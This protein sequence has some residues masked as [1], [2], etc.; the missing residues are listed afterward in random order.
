MRNL[1]TTRQARDGDEAEPRAGLAGRL[2]SINPVLRQPNTWTGALVLA[3]AVVVVGQ[4]PIA[5]RLGTAAPRETAAT[6]APATAGQA[7]VA[8]T[9]N[10]APPVPAGHPDAQRVVVHAPRDPFRALVTPNGAARAPV[11]IQ[12]TH[13]HKPG[14]GPN[15]PS[16]HGTSPAGRCASVHVVRVGESL[17]SISQDNLAKLGYRTV[18]PAWHAVYTANRKAIGSSPGSLAVGTRLC[19]PSA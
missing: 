2:A 19:L 16:G 13:P 8:L 1:A 15:P 12:L 6:A 14:S 5:Q 18:T 7:D 10:A 11:T 9:S 4:H 3:L 17:W